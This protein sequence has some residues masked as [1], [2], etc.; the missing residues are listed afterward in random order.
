MRLAASLFFMFCA[1]NAAG[2]TYYLSPTG[3]DAD[4]GSLANPWKTIGKFFTACAPGDTG[5]CLDGSYTNDSVVTVSH[6]TAGNPIILM[7]SNLFGATISGRINI[8][9]KY[10]VVR[11]FNMTKRFMLNGTN[12]SFGIVEGNKVASGGTI[13]LTASNDPDGQIKH[14]GPNN[15]LVRSNFFALGLEDPT[16]LITGY[17]NLVMANVFSNNSGWDCIRVLGAYNKISSNTF[18]DILLSTN[19]NHTDIIQVFGGSSLDTSNICSHDI[20]FES[21]LI[22]NSHGQ[23]GNLTAVS[24]TNIHSWIFRNNI[25]LNSRSQLNIYLTNVAL[26]NNLIYNDVFSYVADPSWKIREIDGAYTNKA[27]GGTVF[28][29]IFYGNGNE[30]NNGFYSF[31]TGLSNCVADYNFVAFSNGAVKA[32]SEVH[33]ING[34]SPGFVSTSDFHLLTSSILKDAGTNLA[35]LVDLD[36]DGNTRPVNGIWDIGPY[37]FSGSAFGP[38]MT[39]NGKA[40]L[41]GKVTLGQ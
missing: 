40:T 2:A 11:G 21:N 29:N 22:T 37:E 38:R 5:I 34:G 15:N 10:Y 24:S 23:W 16:V 26:L 33:G 31:N 27:H 13:W 39:L 19:D 14:L 8:N 30:T 41:N 36:F 1:W 12:S 4:A 32:I 35:G 17:S 28:N 3:V 7:S 20:I 9:H 25:L 18:V 6:G